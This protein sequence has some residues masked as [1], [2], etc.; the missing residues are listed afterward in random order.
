[1]PETEPPLSGASMGRFDLSEI[2][3]ALWKNWLRGKWV[4]GAFLSVFLGGLAVLLA[5]LVLQGFEGTGLS[6]HTLNGLGILAFFAASSIVLYLA[7]IQ[8]ARP[9]TAVVVSEEGLQ[10]QY[11]TRGTALLRWSDPRFRLSF[12]GY[13]SSV[14]KTL[15][16]VSAVGAFKPRLYASEAAARAIT[17]AATGAGLEVKTSTPGRFSFESVIRIRARR[18]EDP[19]RAAPAASI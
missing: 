6:S 10:V 1:M 11:P 4:G 13:S 12:E 9:A 8:V 15:V 14:A 17:G 7:N 2:S 18:P 5:Y 3:G 16:F 19:P